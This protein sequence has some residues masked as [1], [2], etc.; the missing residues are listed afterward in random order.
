MFSSEDQK[1]LQMVVHMPLSVLERELT[2]KREA[3]HHGK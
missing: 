2:A 3:R 1:L